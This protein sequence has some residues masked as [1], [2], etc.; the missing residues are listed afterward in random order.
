MTNLRCSSS[1]ITQEEGLTLLA[2]LNRNH[3]QKTFRIDPKTGR[4]FFSLKKKKLK[5]Y[6]PTEQQQA[7]ATPDDKMLS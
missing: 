2:C 6:T 1:D 4:G 7:D 5:K 3:R